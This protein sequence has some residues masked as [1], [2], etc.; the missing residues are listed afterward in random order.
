MA[1]S[2]YVPV[3]PP[4]LAAFLLQALAAVVQQVAVSEIIRRNAEGHS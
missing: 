4:L 1:E 2:F 3:L